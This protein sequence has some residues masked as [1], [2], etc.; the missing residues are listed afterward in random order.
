MNKQILLAPS[1]S[2]KTY[3]IDKHKG[4]YNKLFL[5]CGELESAY[6]FYKKGIR[7]GHTATRVPISHPLHKNWEELYKIGVDRLYTEL[8][9]NSCLIYNSA[10]HIPYLRANYSEL[11]VKIVLIDPEK[12]RGFFKG[13][14]KNHKYA[15]HTFAEVV[16]KGDL[17][18]ADVGKLADW[19]YLVEEY[20]QYKRLAEIFGI[21]VY[22][23]FE[24]ALT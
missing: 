17:S 23:S 11:E 6:H 3:F 18:F 24:K 4:E 2:G 14:W 16:L 19:N 9:D 12:R 13:K 7:M 21:K 22:E 20:N 1:C 15:N 5:Y 8:P 10:S